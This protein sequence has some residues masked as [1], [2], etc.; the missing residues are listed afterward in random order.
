MTLKRDAVRHGR[1]SSRVG[2]A[3]AFFIIVFTLLL[4]FLIH[5]MVRHRFFSGGPYTS[6]D[7]SSTP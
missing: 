6:H 5:S 2:L 4:F 1:P 7:N 3:K